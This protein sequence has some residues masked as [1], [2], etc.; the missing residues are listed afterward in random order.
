[1]KII[2]EF[3]EKVVKSKTMSATERKV[4]EI[5]SKIIFKKS[6]VPLILT[7]LI[8]IY[9]NVRDLNIIITVVCTLIMAFASYVYIKKQASK[10][11]N[12]KPYVGTLM[13][14]NKISKRKCVIVL[15]QGENPI[16]LEIHHGGEGL[17]KIKPNHV[18]KMTYNED[19]KIG[20]ILT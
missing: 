5:L 10:Y 16:T 14:Y 15:K 3:N 6:L 13:K 17:E 20:V 18:I 4:S 19:M 7:A 2:N 11:Y 12:F 8:W 1:M 9:G